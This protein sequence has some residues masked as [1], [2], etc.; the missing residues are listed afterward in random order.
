MNQEAEMQNIRQ[1]YLN[2]YYAAIG[3]YK[4]AYELLQS[5]QEAKDS[6]E[7]LRKKM[8]SEDIM[9]QLTEDTIHL[10]QLL[11]MKQNEA[12]HAKTQLELWISSALLIILLMAFALWYNHERKRKLKNSLDII[13]LRLSNARQRISPHFVFNVLNSRMTKSNQQETD[14]L[15]TMAKLIR[16]NL[17]LTS[18][19]YV[20][21]GEELDFVKHYVEIERTL[22][23]E[24]FIFNMKV[25]DESILSKVCLPSMLIQIMTENAIL[26]GLKGKE[27]EKRLCIMVESEENETRISVCDNGPG[28]DIRHY[29]SERSRTGLNIIRTTLSAVNAKNPNAKI[30]YE[31]KN[32]NGCHSIL[33]IPKNIKLI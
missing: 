9:L 1:Q 8:R 33:T 14:Q 16:E 27:G 31:I 20:T 4:R 30:R 21:L 28:F 7:Y 22:I 10:H 24:D 6:T 3:N 23:G 2:N 17:D 19:S 26:H 5:H 11:R 29:N 13:N 15:M 12:M 25:D 32:D 18:K